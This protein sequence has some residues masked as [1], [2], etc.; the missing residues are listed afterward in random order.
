VKIPVR[1][2]RAQFIHCL[3]RVCNVGFDGPDPVFCKHTVQPAAFL[4]PYKMQV[5]DHLDARIPFEAAG[6]P[7]QRNALNRN[8]PLEYHQVRR[9]TADV[10]DRLP[11]AQ[12]VVVVRNVLDLDVC[13]LHEVRA[14]RLIDKFAGDDRRVLLCP[15]HDVHLYALDAVQSLG[16][17]GVVVRKASLKF[18]PGPKTDYLDHDPAFSPAASRAF[19]CALYTRSMPWRTEIEA[20]QPSSFFT[21]SILE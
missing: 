16:Q 2:H 14:A 20:S 17:R 9:Q 10:F 5:E 4:L 12:W 8:G 18:R 15:R 11:P 3:V 6:N 7:A 1:K 19:N 13:P 21:K